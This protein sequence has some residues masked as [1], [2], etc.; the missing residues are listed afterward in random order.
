MPEKFKITVGFDTSDGACRALRWARDEAKLRKGS[1]EIVRA[2]TPGEFG[3]DAEMAQINA[4][5]LEEDAHAILGDRPGVEVTFKAEQGHAAK[6]LMEAGK[7]ADMLV[8]G[9]RGL[10]GFTGLLLGSVSQQCAHHAPCPR[11]I[12]PAGS[13]G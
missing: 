1:L 6:V 9:S 4:K 13:D 12:V 2:W 10:G 7:D 3:T 5:S 11:V 8:V